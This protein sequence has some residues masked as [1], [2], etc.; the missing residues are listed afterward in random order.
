MTM[1]NFELP[2]ATAKAASEAGL[3]TSDALTNMLLDAL[4]RQNP[5]NVLALRNDIAHGLADI[6]AGRVSAFDVD[7]IAAMG[8]RRSANHSHSG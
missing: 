8:R 5:E 3:L 2:D 1:I 4:Q 7:T 6:E